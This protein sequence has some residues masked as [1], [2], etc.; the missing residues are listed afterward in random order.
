MNDTQIQEL[1]G[2]FKASANDQL[3]MLRQQFKV[4]ETGTFAH[5]LVNVL[6]T[7]ME[8]MR[9]DI[10]DAKTLV[11]EAIA[12]IED[13]MSTEADFTHARHTEVAESISDIAKTQRQ[14]A[15][16]MTRDLEKITDIVLRS[17]VNDDAHRAELELMNERMDMLQEVLLALALG[18]DKNKKTS[19]RKRPKA[20]ANPPGCSDDSDSEE[21]GTE[22]SSTP[23]K[24]AEKPNPAGNESHNTD[25]PL[26][27]NMVDHPTTLEGVQLD[28]HLTGKDC[29]DLVRALNRV[30]AQAG[31]VTWCDTVKELLPMGYAALETLQTLASQRD[32][33][34]S[35]RKAVKELTKLR[36]LPQPALTQSNKENKGKPATGTLALAEAPR[37][38][39]PAN[40]RPVTETAS[41]DTDLQDMIDDIPDGTLEKDETHER[42]PR[43]RLARPTPTPAQTELIG[44]CN[45][46]AESRRSGDESQSG[47]EESTLSLPDV[48]VKEA[49]ALF[50]IVQAMYPDNEQIQQLSQGSQRTVIIRGNK[51]RHIVNG[52]DQSP[53]GSYDLE[54]EKNNVPGTT[55]LKSK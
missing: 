5:E 53:T 15:I 36:R 55:H 9:G 19:P 39:K 32:T 7:E 29:I 4:D 2:V 3:K 34:P 50:E 12:E 23:L 44:R 20:P 46:G 27:I 42:G 13:C 54:W 16:D 38:V 21:S 33:N 18:D 41:E 22:D 48:T 10:N 8:S 26:T 52:T 49:H 24:A 1:L 17:E 45:R 37:P 14:Q 51:A 6:Q 47:T 40:K 11:L 43:R 28:D 31:G 30:Q 35:G 25:V